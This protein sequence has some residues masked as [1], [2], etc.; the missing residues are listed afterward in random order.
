MS[1]VDGWYPT[2]VPS[3]VW[4]SSGDCRCFV[5]SRHFGII[6][7]YVAS[8]SRSVNV[9]GHRAL[10]PVKGRP[11]GSCDCGI[12]FNSSRAQ[13]SKRID[14][15]VHRFLVR[16]SLGTPPSP[17]FRLTLAVSSKQ[18]MHTCKASRRA[19]QLVCHL[20][21]YFDYVF[22]SCTSLACS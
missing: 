8:K 16:T 11:Y 17:S 1:L 3:R 6:F 5:T 9:L 22:T 20:P 12:P 14:R 13:L 21:T 7:T 2:S 18:E 4:P 19:H 15:Y 10:F